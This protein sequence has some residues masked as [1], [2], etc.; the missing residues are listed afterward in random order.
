MSDG[1]RSG[2]DGLE[3]D[4]GASAPAAKNQLGP[5]M[6][7]CTLG[8]ATG[9]ALTAAGAL[10]VAERGLSGGATVFGVTDL[11]LALDD[12]PSR[13]SRSA[14]VGRLFFGRAGTGANCSS[15]FAVGTGVALTYVAA[16][17]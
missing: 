4:A 8:L 13:K 6:W 1:C 10:T 2:R 7:V 12:P 5:A 15:G 11:A 9:V 14:R 17:V 3:V 16:F